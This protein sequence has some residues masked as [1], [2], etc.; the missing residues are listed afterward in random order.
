MRLIGPVN[1]PD[2]LKQL[3]QWAIA[4]FDS[5][6]KEAC[7]H[8]SGVGCKICMKIPHTV[9]AKG[10]LW[11]VSVH[12]QLLPFG[13][14]CQAA[15]Y[16]RDRT[17]GI[18][19]ILKATDEYTC[20]DLDYKE[21]KTTTAQ[22]E[23]YNKIIETFNSYTEISTS[24][25]GVH[26]W[27]K[28]SIGEGRKRD[29]VEVYSKERFIVC[30]GNVLLDKPIENRQ[31]L[32][33]VLVS[34]MKSEDKSAQFELKEHAPLY[35]DSEIISMAITA[36]N[37][38]KFNA[39]CRGDWESLGY[40]SQSEADLSLISM[41]AFYSNSN[42]QC[43][44]L[45]RLSALG[46]REKAIKNNRYVDYCLKIV[47]SRQALEMRVDEQTK[48]IAKSVAES[49][50]NTFIVS[51]NSPGSISPEQPH[52]QGLAE[53]IV[54]SR[55]RRDS[56]DWPPG[57]VGEIAKYI[58]ESS[59]RPVKE[60]AIVAALGFMAGVCGKAFS[61]SDTG[62]NVYMI[63]IAQSGVGKEALHEGTG[64]VLAQIRAV[65]P[66]VSDF[67]DFSEY[68]SGSALQKACAKNPCFVNFSNEFGRTLLKRM[69]ADGTDSAISTLRTVLTSLYMKSS[70]NSIVGGLAYSNSSDNVTSVSGVA[71]SIVGE[72]TPGTL[73]ESL[74]ESMLADGFLSRFTMVEYIGDRSPRNQNRKKHLD[75]S[76]LDRVCDVVVQAKTLLSRFVT[77]DVDIAP[78]AEAILDAFDVQC[79]GEVN[80]TQEEGWRQM[81]T[82]AHLKALRFSALLAVADNP[83]EPR[84]EKHHVEWALKLIMR[85]INT[86]S[87]RMLAGDVGRGDS[88]RERKIM[89]VCADYLTKPVPVSYNI[90]DNMRKDGVIPRRFIQ[91]R[92][93][94]LP[95]FSDHKG[96]A[97]MAMDHALRSLCDSGYLAEIPL[98]KLPM[99][100]ATAGKC[101]RILTV[102]NN[103]K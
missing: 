19:F 10:V 13:V 67:V 59:Q 39:L 70:K 21:G 61:I 99:D 54:V 20:I 84:V 47:R 76:T 91:L 57:I 49:C 92:V 23:R 33:D 78:D 30:T 63:L 103:L 58:F 1:L 46:R 24:G 102:P 101:Y 55:D 5:E 8:C 9:D 73:Y 32:L 72:T 85:D 14:A 88:V 29:G 87:S 50:N 64:N 94:R 53:P 71:Y 89:C 48:Q 27:V 17:N 98:S 2:E 45:F 86:I 25:K 36:T 31:E 28:G 26:I 75:D 3:P 35:E 74:T 12:N 69:A 62:L 22:L 65:V 38:D 83:F 82:R 43:R 11:K 15:D 100:Y 44:R 96:G 51:D 18:G 79:D 40:P 7:G 41:L 4:S 90:P 66:V 56:I 95:Q 52:S 93:G 42:E 97:I 37:A 81:W 60:V 80:S 34:E 6:A 16:Y 77:Q 68:K